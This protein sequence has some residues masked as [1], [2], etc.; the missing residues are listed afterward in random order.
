[1]QSARLHVACI[2]LPALSFMVLT[3]VI[4]SSLTCFQPQRPSCSTSHSPLALASVCSLCPVCSSPYNVDDSLNLALLKGHITATK[5]FSNPLSKTAFS[6]HGWASTQSPS[7]TCL[8]IVDHLGV[9]SM[10]LATQLVSPLS[11]MGECRHHE[12]KVLG[13]VYCCIPDILERRIRCSEYHEWPLSNS[14]LLNT[15]TVQSVT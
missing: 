10:Y 14:C 11:L 12:N 4:S 2:L 15:F 9:S 13:F 7:L 6:L 5:E 3:P 8:V 1:M